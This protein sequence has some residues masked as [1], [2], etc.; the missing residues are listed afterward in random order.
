MSS[1]AKNQNELV[2]NHV[3][4]YLD[5]TKW[6][7]NYQHQGKQRRV[8]LRT[9]SKKEARRKAALLDAELLQG[10]HQEKPRSRTIPEVCDAYLAHMNVEEKAA[11]TLAKIDLVI[12]RIKHM[13]TEKKLRNIDEINL[14]FVDA[15]RASRLVERTKKKPKPK[16]LLNETVIIRQVVNFALK[17]EWLQRDPLKNLKLKKV[18]PGAQPCWTLEQ[19]ELILAAAR[20]AY[21]N[22]LTILAETG[23]RVGEL[24]HLTWQDVD[25][26]ANVLLIRPKDGWKPKT[27]DQ[28]AIPISE[29]LIGVLQSMPRRSPWVVTSPRVPAG[30]P[31]FKQ[32]SERRLLQSL[33]TTLK[34]LG[35]PGHLHT[36]RHTFIS[37]ALANGTTEST[38]RSW[39]G[40]LDPETLKTYTHVHDR[41]SQAEMHRLSS[42]KE[43]ATKPAA[44]DSPKA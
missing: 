5:G 41:T 24:K 11:K 12:R 31:E 23:M 9:S 3:R 10:T 18:K 26:T 35:L 8:S 1:S 16:T 7:A 22:A 27:G 40:H 28:R 19:L 42:K 34:K 25:F 4:I 37:S 43:A 44:V 13:A 15:Y 33:K 2:G 30:G 38:L 36:F 21:L 39:V 29:R 6:Y 14:V 17:R 20:P 32:V